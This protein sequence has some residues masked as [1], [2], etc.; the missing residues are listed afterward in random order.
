MRPTP[1]QWKALIVAHQTSGLTMAEFCR[2]RKIR[3]KSFYY[4]HRKL[5]AVKPADEAFVQVTLPSPKQVSACTLHVGSVS[6]E[7]GEVS[8]S[9]LAALMKALA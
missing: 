7:L 3:P 2:E 6:L 4:W 5:G 9:W 1:E 8:P